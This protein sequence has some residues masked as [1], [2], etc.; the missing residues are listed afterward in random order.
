MPTTQSSSASKLLTF[1]SLFCEAY[2]CAPQKARKRMFWLT[3]HLRALPAAMLFMLVRPR[4]F[5]LDFQL[6][7]EAANAEN[8]NELVA[9]L[10]GFQQDC[11]ASR[12]FLHDDMRFRISGKRLISVFKKAKARVRSSQGRTSLQTS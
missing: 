7:D 5:T 8:I 6:L 11:A 1:E 4:F 9:A 2:H 10:N 3:L 12:R